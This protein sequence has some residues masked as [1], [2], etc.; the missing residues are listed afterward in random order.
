MTMEAL[1]VRI[2]AVA[3]IWRGRGASI[4][5]LTHA[6]GYYPMSFRRSGRNGHSPEDDRLPAYEALCLS[7]SRIEVGSELSER[8]RAVCLT[9]CHVLLGMLIDLED[10]ISDLRHLA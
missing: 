7:M 9:T 3:N 1:L 6:N 2:V 10:A 5:P 4:P 8:E